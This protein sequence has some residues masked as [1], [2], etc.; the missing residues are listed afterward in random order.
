VYWINDGGHTLEEAWIGPTATPLR[1]AAFYPDGKIIATGTEGWFNDGGCD[2]EALDRSYG[3]IPLW[4]VQTGNPI[5]DFHLT[6]C[7]IDYLEFSADGGN[8]LFRGSCFFGETG[9][10]L[11]D[12]ETGITTSFYPEKNSEYLSTSDMAISSDGNRIATGFD[13]LTDYET[14]SHS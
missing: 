4:D 14:D 5:R 10:A 2:P 3:F 11:F 9:P 8:I 12:P 6:N 7:F 13:I 1:S